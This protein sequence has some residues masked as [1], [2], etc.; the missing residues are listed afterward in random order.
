MK[1]RAALAGAVLASL[2]AGAAYLG[3]RA[4]L[5]RLPGFA[6]ERVEVVGARLLTPREVMAT[7][8]MR[9]GS[10]IWADG[11]PLEHALRAN[12]VVRAA[13]IER[14]LP[15]TL[16]VVLTEKRAAALV[17]AGTLLPATAEGEILPVDPARVPLDLPLVR[18]TATP[19][20]ERRVRDPGARILLAQAGRIAVLAPAL[21]ARISEFRAGRAPGEMRLSIGRPAAEIVAPVDASA[22]T[23]RALEAVLLDVARRYPA[24]SGAPR[25]LDARFAG[26]VV[27][28][29]APRA[30]SRPSSPTTR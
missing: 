4:V 2:V 17:E 7:S 29:T 21:A 26:Q 14:R 1:G 28:R 6:V 5:T 8:G 9:L 19:A 18:G 22:Q 23:L 15:H 25:L 12:P 13:R 27:V 10:T 20:A 30:V 16:R 3:G 11:A 24:A